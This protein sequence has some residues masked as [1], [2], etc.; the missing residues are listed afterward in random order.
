MSKVSIEAFNAIIGSELPSAAETGIY[1][2]SI[3]HGQAGLGTVARQPGFR[4]AVPGA[5]MSSP[6]LSGPVTASSRFDVAIRN[7]RMKSA[8]FMNSRTMAVH[9]RLRVPGP[10]PSRETCRV[11]P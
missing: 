8:F 2:R 4:V 3:E 6:E 1:L 5:Q 10:N 11:Y 7:R 9:L